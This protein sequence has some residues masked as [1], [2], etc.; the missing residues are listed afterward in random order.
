MEKAQQEEKVIAKVVVEVSRLDVKVQVEDQG[1]PER[2]EIST[3][4][5][6]YER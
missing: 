2:S 4:E 1:H 6:K 3:L 5:G